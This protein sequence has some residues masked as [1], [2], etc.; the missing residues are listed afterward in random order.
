MLL[1][2][3]TMLRFSH[4]FHQLLVK[5]PTPRPRCHLTLALLAQRGNPHDLRVTQTHGQTISKPCH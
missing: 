3:I 5:R 4:S 1:L 2:Q